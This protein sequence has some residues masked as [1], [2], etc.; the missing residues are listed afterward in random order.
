MTIQEAKAK[1]VAW[2]KDQVDYEEGY[3][4]YKHAPFTYL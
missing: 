1:L 3:N 2:C 4:N